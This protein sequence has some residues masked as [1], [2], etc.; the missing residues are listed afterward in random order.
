MGLHIVIGFDRPGAS[1]EPSL[2]YLGKSG[3]EARAEMDK[4]DANRFEI[5][6]NPVGIRKHNSASAARREAA[7]KKAKKKE[8]TK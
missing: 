2:V 5:F 4:S 3:E 8:P 1:A 7:A 6:R